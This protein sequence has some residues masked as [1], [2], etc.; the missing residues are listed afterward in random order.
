MHKKL[1]VLMLTTALVLV[2]ANMAAASSFEDALGAAYENNPHIKAQRQQLESTDEGVAQA[3]SGFRPTIGAEYDKGRQRTDFGGVGWSYGNAETKQ[4]NVTQPLFRG[5]GTW[6]SY[7]SAEQ[8]VRAGQFTL[9]AVEQD[10]M[11]QAITAYMDV[12][13]N[14]AILELARNN[15][16]VLAKQLEAANTR[17][18]VGEVTRTD[19]AQSEARLS[20]AKSSVI[21]AEGQVKS[22]LAT[23]TR[24]IGYR[25]E[26]TLTVPDKLPEL[27]ASLDEALE[28]GRTMNPQLL[29]AIHTAK[30][31]SYDVRTNEATLLPQVSLVGTMER[32]EGA[33]SNGGSNFD[34]DRLMLQVSVPLYQ[35][36]AEYSRVREA[37]AIARQRDHESIDTRMATDQSISQS[38]EQLETSISTITAREDQI[39]A[40]QVALEGVRQEQEY[41]SRTVLD[42]LD[43]EQELFTARTNLV[44]AQ[45]DRI[46]DAYSLAFNLGQLTPTNLGLNVEQYDPTVHADHVKWKPIG[47]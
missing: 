20:D 26:G 9:S 39:K 24:V 40:A 43:A 33:G 5:G 34:Q 21:A 25:P 46:V 18:Q 11:L 36:G 38:W 31:S 22:S 14:C 23:F 27:P 3:L 37:S 15:Q 19:V 47:F 6:S 2:G 42:V 44:R 13:A 35:S 10:V 4:L 30:S 29:A 28:R 16:D 1:R 17:F 45:R 32:Q 8:R 41:G 12:V 7:K